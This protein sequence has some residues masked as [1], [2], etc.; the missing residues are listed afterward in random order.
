M[1]ICVKKLE[2]FFIK[3]EKNYGPHN[4]AI[5]YS[6]I[7][8]LLYFISSIYMKFS[9]IRE[10]FYLFTLWRGIGGFTWSAIL[11]SYKKVPLNIEDSHNFKFLTIKNFLEFHNQ[12]LFVVL[13][14]YLPISE[15]FILTNLAPFFLCIIQLAF[16]KMTINKKEIFGII[17]SIIGVI[18]I[19]KPNTITKLVPFIQF[20]VE[21]KPNGMLIKLI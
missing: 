5:I 6:L 11:L 9:I 1:K 8:G 21:T 15:I 3:S 2:K 13:I 20:Y 17:L 7:Y 10:K 4:I 14:N 18:F 12:I 19:M 16:Y